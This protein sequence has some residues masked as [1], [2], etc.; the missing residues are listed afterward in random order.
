MK[1]IFL[2]LSF[3]SIIKSKDL[4]LIQAVWRHGDRAP[5]G[6]YPNDPYPESSWPV[7][8]GELTPL[9]MD[10]HFRQGLKIKER[11]VNQ[12]RLLNSTYK[13]TEVSARSTDVDRCLVSAY[14]SLAGLYSDSVTT[15]PTNNAKWPKNWTPIPVHTVP[16]KDDNVKLVIIY[17]YNNYIFSF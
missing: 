11:Y 7:P 1:I 6:G 8:W 15:Y 10:Q 9:G 3:V 5:S 4:L 13:K 2:L 14:S 16:D 17:L 12:F